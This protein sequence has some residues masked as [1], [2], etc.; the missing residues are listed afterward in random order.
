MARE[1]LDRQLGAL[2][3]AVD[4]IAQKLVDLETDSTRQLLDATKLGGESAKQSAAACGRPARNFGARRM[5]VPS[6]ALP[7][8]SALAEWPPRL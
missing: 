7:A 8:A 1:G 5:P 4:W 6:I 2:R 3:D